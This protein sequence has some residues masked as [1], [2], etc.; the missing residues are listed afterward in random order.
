MPRRAPRVAHTG[1]AARHALLPRAAHQP[2]TAPAPAALDGRAGHP[3]PGRRTKYTVRLMEP[4]RRIIELMFLTAW[5]DGRFE[6]SEALAIHKLAATVPQ[7]RK[8]TRLNSSHSSISYAVF[9][10]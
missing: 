2:R 4:A 7:D 10:L 8:S 1:A 9:C 5:A 3:D 6:G